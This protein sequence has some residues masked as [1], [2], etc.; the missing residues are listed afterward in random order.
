MAV[1]KGSL[2]RVSLK[3]KKSEIVTLIP[4]NVVDIDVSAVSFKMVS[5]NEKMQESVKTFGV[6]LP[7]IVEEGE[8]G[9]KVIDGAKRLTA[10]KNL[11]VTTVKAVVINGNSKKVNAELKKF[12]KVE[13]IENN[14]VKNDDLHEEKFNVIKRLGEDEMPVYLL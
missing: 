2:N 3:N 14:N 8:K 4:N 1:G 13:I 11:G 5:D 7:V 9:L 6:I 10:L 12:D